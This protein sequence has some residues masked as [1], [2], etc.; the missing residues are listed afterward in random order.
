VLDPIV[1]DALVGRRAR[2]AQ[3][4][5]RQLNARELE[6]LARM[7]EGKTNP[8]ELALSESAIEKNVN[9]IFSKLGLSEEAQ[10]YRR[11]AA[12]LAFVR[13]AGDTGMR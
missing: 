4:P 7:A 3:S 9:A 13:E 10:V 2:Q 11:V 8:A 12:V 5:S 6:V 1:V